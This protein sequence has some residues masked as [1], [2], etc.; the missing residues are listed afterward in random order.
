MKL[1]LYNKVYEITSLLGPVEE[2][3]LLLKCDINTQRDV[4][5]FYKSLTIGQVN[6][7]LSICVMN[8]A[9]LS[10]FN[11]FSELLGIEYI[12]KDVT[13]DVVLGKFKTD[14]YITN[15]IINP[16]LEDNLSIDMILDKINIKGINGL[17]EVDKK[18]LH[19]F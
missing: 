8:D 10:T 14:E 18:V 2:H 16:F 1:D 3:N 19:N 6:E 4:F 12:V 9:E 17:S 15:T 7:M 13:V 5:N 11:K